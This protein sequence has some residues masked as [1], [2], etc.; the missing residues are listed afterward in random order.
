ME[1]SSVEALSVR[2][3][4]GATPERDAVFDED[5]GGAVGG[6]LCVKHSMHYSWCTCRARASSLMLAVKVLRGMQHR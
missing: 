3:E 6:E 2:G 4:T 1:Q 5:V